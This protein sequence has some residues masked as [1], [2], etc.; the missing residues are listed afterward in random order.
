MRNLLLNTTVH[1]GISSRVQ[2]Q[3][4]AVVNKEA[5]KVSRVEATRERALLS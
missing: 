1:S 5:M 4:K 3:L 2:N